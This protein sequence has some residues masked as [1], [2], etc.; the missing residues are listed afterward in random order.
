[1]FPKDDIK[2]FKP[3]KLTS[4]LFWIIFLALM[5]CVWLIYQIYVFSFFIALIFYLILRKPYLTLLR[6][7]GGQKNL[8]S[9][10]ASVFTIIVIVVPLFFLIQTLTE[11]TFIAI[12]HLQHW[13]TKENLYHF[14]EENEWIRYVADSLTNEY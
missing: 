10:I 3:D 6:I 11:E 13:L 1:M 8:A 2:N 14:Y 7:L 12:G 4:L 9:I 5:Y